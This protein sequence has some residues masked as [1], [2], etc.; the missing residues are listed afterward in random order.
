MTLKSI[1][2]YL[3]LIGEFLK[4]CKKLNT[5][6]VN[7]YVKT[8]EEIWQFVNQIIGE[9]TNLD[10]IVEYTVRIVKSSLRILGRHF[11]KYLI[12]FLQIVVKAY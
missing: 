1:Q 12:P 10:E 5:R 6:T 11:D 9:F 8:F 3:Y 7:P 2:N 4:G